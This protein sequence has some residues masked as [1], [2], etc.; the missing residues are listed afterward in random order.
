MTPLTK[1]NFALSRSAE[2]PMGSSRQP[3]SGAYLWGDHWHSTT[4][5]NYS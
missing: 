3:Y 2:R 4:R 1:P 5:R